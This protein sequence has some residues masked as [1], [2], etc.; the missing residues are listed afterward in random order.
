MNYKILFS[1]LF[2]FSFMLFIPQVSAF[3]VEAC[4][5]PIDSALVGGL[6]AVQCTS[7]YLSD[8]S[9]W[10]EYQVSF[11]SERLESYVELFTGNRNSTFEE[12]YSYYDANA[13]NLLVW[14]DKTTL[15]IYINW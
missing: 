13:T 2:L 7:G 4:L 6:S 12:I 5:T 3:I 15:P 8:E 9:G 14:V 1:L 11:T 10:C